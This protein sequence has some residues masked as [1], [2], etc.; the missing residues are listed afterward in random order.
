MSANLRLKVTAAFKPHE[1]V[2]IMLEWLA[3]DK[4]RAIDCGDVKDFEIYTGELPLSSAAE[5]EVKKGAKKEVKGKKKDE[6]ALEAGQVY[7]GFFEAVE[8]DVKI[9]EV[10]WWLNTGILQ[11]YL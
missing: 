3:G 1:D 10:G 5:V 7:N 4:T 11:G 9:D 6:N 8:D 2:A